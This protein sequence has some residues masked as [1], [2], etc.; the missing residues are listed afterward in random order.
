MHKC[1]DQYMSDSAGPCAEVQRAFNDW[2]RV[3]PKPTKKSKDH[4]ARRWQVEIEATMDEVKRTIKKQ[5]AVRN[6][7]EA[8]ICDCGHYPHC[9][10]ICVRRIKERD[11]CTCKFWPLCYP[12]CHLWLKNF[13]VAEESY[14]QMRVERRSQ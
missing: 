13:K 10:P 14:E 2:R 12:Q 4:W 7:E 8:E 1:L 5:D 11:G 3:H 6:K 9:S